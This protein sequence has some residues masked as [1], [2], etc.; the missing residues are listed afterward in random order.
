MGKE[1][2]QTQ[3]CNWLGQ[4][5]EGGTKGVTLG[6]GAQKRRD[7]GV[8]ALRSEAVMVLGAGKL[9]KPGGMWHVFK[10]SQSKNCPEICQFQQITACT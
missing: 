8:A 5:Q 1:E 3:R 2:L 4:S 9:G 7:R 6:C 10:G